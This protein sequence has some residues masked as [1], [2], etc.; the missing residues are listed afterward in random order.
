[1]ASRNFDATR[2][3]RNL[4]TLLNLQ[5]GTTYFIQNV[6]ARATLRLRQAAVKPSSGMRAHKIEA[7]GDLLI[8]PDSAAGGT[9]VWTDE[10]LCACIVTEAPS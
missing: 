10:D 9:W 1:M 8:Q 2:D 3:P 5:S 7:G 6:D 4:D